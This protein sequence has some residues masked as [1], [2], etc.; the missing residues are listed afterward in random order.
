MTDPNP[1]PPWD[2]ARGYPP[3]AYPTSGY[4][5]PP[6]A[7]PGYGYAGPAKTNGLAIA[8]LVC[9]LVGLFTCLPATV[10][11]ILGHVA[12]RQIRERGEDGDGLALAGIIVG[13]IVTALY[14]GY[15]A[16]VVIAILGLAGAQ[17]AFDSASAPLVSR[18][19]A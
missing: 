14:V 2:P 13:W 16:F 3:P 19:A 9:A 6:A 17:G 18:P 5:A 11:A 7:Y 8:A 4:V 12:R 10:G 1:Q 15:L